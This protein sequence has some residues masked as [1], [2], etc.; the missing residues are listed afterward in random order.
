MFRF[1]LRRVGTA[2]RM[3]QSERTSAVSRP[4]SQKD[5]RVGMEGNQ[6]SGTRARRGRPCREQM[7][8]GQCGLKEGTPSWAVAWG[9]AQVGGRRGAPSSTGAGPPVRT[10][11]RREQTLAVR[12]R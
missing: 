9:Q 7:A 1:R 8:D 11:G 6:L 3:H 4:I 5:T 10:A 12:V 2:T